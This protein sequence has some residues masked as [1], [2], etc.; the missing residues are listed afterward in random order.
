ML[1]KNNFFAVWRPKLG[2]N[3][4]IHII[5]S[6]NLDK[7]F[8]PMDWIGRELV[9]MLIPWRKLG[10]SIV[11]FGADLGEFWTSNQS[12]FLSPCLV[13]RE[14]KWHLIFQFSNFQS[15]FKQWR[16]SPADS[17]T[18]GAT[19]KAHY[20]HQHQHWHWLSS[21]HYWVWVK[22]GWSIAKSAPL[23]LCTT[24]SF[25]AHFHSLR[26]GMSRMMGWVNWTL[27]KTFISTAK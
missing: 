10:Q 11:G 7:V 12:L 18:I 5:H 24:I 4:S 14:G 13:K 1:K 9:L 17:L 15:P 3:I 26:H 27:T 8:V 23:S 2:H 25:W 22:S 16:M 19:A 21:T 20:Q 6:L